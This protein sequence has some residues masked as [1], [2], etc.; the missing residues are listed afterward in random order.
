MQRDGRVAAVRGTHRVR[1]GAMHGD[2]QVGVQVVALVDH[3]QLRLK[4]GI[5]CLDGGD[6]RI[7]HHSPLMTALVFDLYGAVALND[8]P[9]VNSV[10][11][12]YGR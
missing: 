5:E 6:W 1:S 10:C 7:R 9:F 4:C 8:P 11:S 3:G 2:K 12:R